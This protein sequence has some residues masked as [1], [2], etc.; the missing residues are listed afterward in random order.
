MID[1]F[2][3]PAKTSFTILRPLNNAISLEL[4]WGV[5]NSPIA[6]AFAYAHSSKWH[7]LTGTWCKF[8]VPQLD[9]PG[10]ERIETA[11]RNYMDS[12]ARHE[13][14][15][16]LRSDDT[17][18]EEAKV[19]RELQWRIDAEVMRLYELPVEAERQLLDYF[20]GWERVGVPFKQDR[21]FPEGF[22]E[23]ISLTD[24]LAITAGWEATN[25]RRLELIERKA[26]N[27]IRTEERAELQRL[28]R[29]A[30]LKR[31]LL[32]SPSLKE[33]AEVEADLRRRGLWRGA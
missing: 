28:Q 4:L 20:S 6:N 18:V 2:G 11:V 16:P 3:R 29:L 10:I 22:D 23:A 25:K 32:S 15:L 30:G 8:P 24:F 19:L 26:N 31:E 33:L 17:R 5:L 9:G 21:Y 27:P 12:V 14:H 1:R 13:A 7:I